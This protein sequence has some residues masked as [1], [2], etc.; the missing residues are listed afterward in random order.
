M[1]VVDIRML[2]SL[3]MVSSIVGYVDSCYI[4]YQYGSYDAFGRYGTII[5]NSE[6]YVDGATMHA[7]M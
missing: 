2:F 3:S 4:G 6:Q 5:L 1:K 7:L